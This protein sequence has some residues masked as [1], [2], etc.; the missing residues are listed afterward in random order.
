[1][2]SLIKKPISLDRAHQMATEAWLVYNKT[3]GKTLA[4]KRCQNCKEQWRKKGSDITQ[5]P[6]RFPPDFEGV[7]PVCGAELVYSSMTL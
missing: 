2:T 5:R 4:G 7:C 3:H 6:P 1:M